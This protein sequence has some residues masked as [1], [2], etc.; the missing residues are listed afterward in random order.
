MRLIAVVWIAL[1]CAVAAQEPAQPQ[2]PVVVTVGEATVRRAPDRAFV[3]V[4]V[5][6]RSKSPRDAQRLN[7]E[8]MTAVQ[9]RLT[10]ARIAK[11]AIRTTG[12][13]LQ[14]EFDF[15]QGRRVLRE[16][17]A[18]NGIEV[19]VDDIARTGEML[20]AVVQSGATSVSGIRFDLQ[21]RDS[22]EREAL[23]LAVA[24]ARA[25]A[26]AA[27]SGAG[28]AIDRVLRIEDSRDTGIMP[29]RPMMTM[30]R[31]A[32]SPAQTPVEPGLIE[33]HARVTLTA[34]MK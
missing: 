12:Y 29:P 23:R 25:R 5:E 21:D 8:A 30:A 26:E 22:V 28:R 27:A 18:R 11:D 6:T 31:T 15:V 17:V 34:S 19:R 32:E 9:Q 4:S 16:F 1:A 3:T 33:I 14:Q 10:Q 24:D 7:A 13:D 20:D 2:G